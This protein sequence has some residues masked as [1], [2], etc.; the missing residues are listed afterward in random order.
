[1]AETESFGIIDFVGIP[2]VR[3]KHWL[4]LRKD[5]G[6]P[7]I[8]PHFFDVCNCRTWRMHY[9]SIGGICY[10]VNEPECLAAFSSTR[11]SPI[12]HAAEY[13]QERL[14]T[15]IVHRK[16]LDRQLARW[17]G[18]SEAPEVDERWPRCYESEWT[19]YF[20]LRDLLR[21][22]PRRRRCMVCRRPARGLYARYASAGKRQ[23]LVCG[24]RCFSIFQSHKRRIDRWNAHLRERV[25]EELMTRADRERKQLR[26]ERRE[27]ANCRQQLT[28]F[29]KFLRTGD[30]EALKSLPEGFGPRPSSPT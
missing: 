16:E 26:D 1:M 8:L 10:L 28:S 5:P 17:Y 15:P 14:Q 11:Y 19:E 27:L 30:P 20:A 23:S 12:K 9:F 21:H 25:Y 22:L 4:D 24:E 3:I 18:Q 29:R 6:G 2:K 13:L 7:R